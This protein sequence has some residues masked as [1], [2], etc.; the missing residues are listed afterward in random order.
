[1]WRRARAED[2]FIAQ[3]RA[4]STMSAHGP[5]G[6]IGKRVHVERPDISFVGVVLSVVDDPCSDEPSYLLEVSEGR[7]R[8]ERRGTWWWFITD[9][10]RVA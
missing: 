3:A 6:L 7:R 5:T 9:V 2:A 10:E 1:L 8:G 4:W